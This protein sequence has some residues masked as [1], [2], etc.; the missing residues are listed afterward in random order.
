MAATIMI[1]IMPESQNR[2]DDE[3]AEELPGFG[4]FK[5]P[6]DR[7]KAVYCTAYFGLRIFRVLLISKNTNKKYNN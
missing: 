5:R 6:D 4:F 7:N 1:N 3:K 2:H